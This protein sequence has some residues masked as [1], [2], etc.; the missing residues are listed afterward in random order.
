M[1]LVIR[2]EGRLHNSKERTRGPHGEEE[3]IILVATLYITITNTDYSNFCVLPKSTDR[4]KLEK[5]V[6]MCSSSPLERN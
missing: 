4:L 3:R 2:M 6:R 1:D 5:K